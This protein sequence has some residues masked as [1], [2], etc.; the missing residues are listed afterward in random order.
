MMILN[1]VNFTQFW[2]SNDMSMKI[3]LFK[4]YLKAQFLTHNLNIEPGEYKISKSYGF[5]QENVGFYNQ[6]Q[7]GNWN[8]NIDWTPAYMPPYEMSENQT[9]PRIWNLRY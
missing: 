8:S 2:L 5:Q 3:F 7:P 9:M 6:F 4:P 1:L